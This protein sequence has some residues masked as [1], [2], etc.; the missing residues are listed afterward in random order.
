MSPATIWTLLIVSAIAGLIVRVVRVLRWN[1][2]ADQ[3][4][5]PARW[6]DVEDRPD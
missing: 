5:P 6:D 3:W 1:R 2:E 4:L